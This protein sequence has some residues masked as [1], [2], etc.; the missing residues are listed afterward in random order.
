MGRRASDGEIRLAVFDAEA[1]ARMDEIEAE[2]ERVL[3]L[4]GDVRH[5][6]RFPTPTVAE[7]YD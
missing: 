4:F 5:R 2:A 7:L 1:D 6:P 3:A